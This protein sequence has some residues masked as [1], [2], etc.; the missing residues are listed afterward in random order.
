[1]LQQYFVVSTVGV[2]DTEDD[3][4]DEAEYGAEEPLREQANTSYI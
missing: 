1:V 2:H 3:A 4:H